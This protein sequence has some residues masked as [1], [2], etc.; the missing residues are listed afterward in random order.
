MMTTICYR[1]IEPTIYNKGTDFEK[2]CDELL[3]Y[4]TCKSIEEATTEVET[5][6]TTK[7]STMF[8][9][10]KIDWNNIKEFFV[11]EQELF[12]QKKK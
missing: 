6:N 9:G 2:R 8:N 7:P 11:D 4:Y 3:A 12:N 5:L 10:E 1:T